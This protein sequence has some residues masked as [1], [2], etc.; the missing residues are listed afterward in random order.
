MDVHKTFSA[1]NNLTMRVISFLFIVFS[2]SASQIC[3]SQEWKKYA[4]SVK[5]YN[6][7]K[8]PD[9]AFANYWRAKELMPESSV[10]IDTLSLPLRNLAVQ[11]YNN[12]ETEQVV[13]VSRELMSIASNT[14]SEMNL[15]YAWGL[16]MI[17]VIYNNAGKLDTARAFYLRSKE[18][19][20]KLANKSPAYAQ[21][22]NNLGSL[23]RDLGRYDLA[24]PLL[25]EAKEIRKALPPEMREQ[26]ATTCVSLGNLYKDLGQY[27]KAE[28]YYLQA[29]DIR[30]S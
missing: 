5:I 18:I 19:R 24:E 27:E 14:Y 29:K 26:Y 10:F 11:Y 9:K 1:I 17:G 15:D 21:S 20:Q 30:G 28:S 2:V 6:D 7:K 23:Y 16:N 4:D 22:C 3:Y 25:I 12:G 8:T 13:A